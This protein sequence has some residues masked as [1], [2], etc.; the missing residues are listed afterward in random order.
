[1]IL[2]YSF[3]TILAIVLL[4]VAALYLG[5]LVP[6]NR[7][8]Q[9]LENGID[10]FV[11]TNGMHLDFIVPAQNKLMDWTQ[12]VDSR[13]FKKPL[14]EYTYLGIGWG[15][16]EFYLEL[17]TWDNVPFDVGFRALAIP[18]PTIMHLIGYDELPYQD[19][20]VRKI[21][22]SPSQYLHLCSYIYNSFKLDEENRIQLIPGA[23]YTENDNFY[24]AEGN[25]HLFHTCNYWINKGLK[26]IGVY[27]PVW[28]PLE[29]RVLYQ[30]DKL[31]AQTITTSEY[32]FEVPV[33][34]AEV[35]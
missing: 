31:D 13:P 27:A 14:Q 30:L 33:K 10:I 3:L 34:T 35:F 4:F 25:Y 21:T 20:K 2:G 6:V 23:G 16:P 8:F 32:A 17:E 1:M 28:S 5:A 7:K 24:H 15:A 12:I 19:L 9:L 22:I 26:K 29:K 11:S 18:S